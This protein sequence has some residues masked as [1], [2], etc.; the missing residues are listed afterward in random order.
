MNGADSFAVEEIERA[1]KY[2]RP[3]YVALFVDWGLQ[4]VV[5]AAILLVVLVSEAISAYIRARIS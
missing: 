1:R 3:L 5:L 2:H 4:L